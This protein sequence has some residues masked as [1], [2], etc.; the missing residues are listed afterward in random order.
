M[1]DYFKANLTSNPVALNDS[2]NSIDADASTPLLDPEVIFTI[3]EAASDRKAGDILLLKV[4]DVSYLADY[5]VLLSGY[6]KVQVRAIADAVEGAMEEKWERNPLRTEGKAEGTWILQDYG[7]VIV[8]IMMPNERE[9]YNLEAF[10][11]HGE[12][13]EFPKKDDDGG[14]N[15]HD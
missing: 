2:D 13:M 14:V 9:F 3:A 11:G 15:Q 1:T 7:D 5:F 6:S 8:H 10:W 4:S 12:R